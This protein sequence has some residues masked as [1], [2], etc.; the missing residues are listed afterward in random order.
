MKIIK[1]GKYF[2]VFPEEKNIDP[3]MFLGWRQ[4]RGTSFYIVE[5]N[6]VNRMVLGQHI[7]LVQSHKDLENTDMLKDYQ[8]RDI[9][10]M[11]GLTHCLNANPMGL[12]KTPETIRFLQARNARAALIVCPKIIRYQWQE[13]LRA[14]GNMESQVYENQ[15]IITEGIWIINYDKLR[16]EKTRMKFKRFQWEYLILD[17]AHKIKSRKSQQ[18]LAVKDLPAQHRIALTGTPVLRYVDDLWSILNFLD[19]FYSGISYWSFV[20]Y[21][22]EIQK[23]PWGNKIVGLTRSTEKIAILNMLLDFIGVRNDA[24][25]VAHGKTREVVK[26]PMSKKQRELYRK[27]KDLVLD[28]LPENLT[29]A[30]GA[31]LAL[32]LMQTTSWPGLFIENECGPKFEWILEACLN[33]PHEKFVVFSVFEKTVQALCAYLSTN[34]V[35]AVSITGTNT[36]EDNELHKRQFVEGNVQVLAGT[37]KKMGQGYDGLQSVCRLMIFIDRDWSPAIMEQAEDRLRRM[38]QDNPVHV[39]YLECTGSFDQYVGRI[40]RTKASNI[41]EALGGTE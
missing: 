17:E 20:N 30:N 37:I 27:E 29:I 7:V 28:E 31:T 19:V 38:G 40:N 16:N 25:E 14:W 34:K 18:T 11:L 4:K 32:R 21:F 3:N 23:T 10:K 26:L 8:I 15:K 24:V 1:Q 9:N 2:H 5:D 6:L 33:N 36:P 13:Q 22:C 41:R 39:Y 35:S 12:G